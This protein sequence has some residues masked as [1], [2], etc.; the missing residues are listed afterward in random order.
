MIPVSEKLIPNKLIRLKT[1]QR[2]VHHRP[3]QLRPGVRNLISISIRVSKQYS[4]SRS[5]RISSPSWLKILCHGRNCT[6]WVLVGFKAFPSNMMNSPAPAISRR[7]SRISCFPVPASPVTT[8]MPPPS[9]SCLGR[10][11]HH[12]PPSSRRAG[13]RHNHRRTPAHSSS[14]DHTRSV[15]QSVHEEVLRRVQI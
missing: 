4:Y 10:E 11:Q 5:F 6:A 2:D 3:T 12:V 13:V 1:K 8:V 14:H 7:G 15:E 9:A